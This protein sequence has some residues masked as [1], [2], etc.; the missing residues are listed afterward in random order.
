MAIAT[1]L[2]THAGLH[3]QTLP[4]PPASPAPQVSF[5]YDAE[6]NLRGTLQQ[7]PGAN[8]VTRHEHD[9]L[10]RR[11]RTIDAR[12]NSVWQV[13]NGRDDLTGV[14]DP[15]L[16]FTQY[17]RDGLGNMLSLSSPDT[18]TARI[19]FDAAGNLRTRVDSR[20]VLAS[21]S[22]DALNRLTGLDF[23]AG[24]GSQTFAWTYDQ[25][26]NDHAH[27]VGRLTT[28]QFPGGFTRYAY[29]AQGRLSQSV[30]TVNTSAGAVTTG[31][32]YGRDAAGRVNRVT[33]PSGR[34]LHI[35][36][37]GGVPSALSLAPF[38]GGMALPLL[39]SLQFEPG[40][41]GAG[42]LRSWV[43]QLSAGTLA[44]ERVFD[45]H[46]RMVRHPLGGAVRDIVYDAADRIA[47][48]SHLDA[49][50]GQASAA[51][52]ALNQ[53]FGYDELGRLTT[54]GTPGGQWG[55][56]YDDNGNRT[57]LSYTSGVVSLN[58]SHSV[59]PASNRV[60]GVASP[61][62]SFT[63][64]ATGHMTGTAEAGHGWTATVDPGGRIQ[65]IQSVAPMGGVSA[66][67]QYLHNAA[68]LRVAK[69]VL[70]GGTV[71][72]NPEPIDPVICP[73]SASQATPCP[74]QPT[75]PAVALGRGGGS[76]ATASSAGLNAEVQG[77]AT[78]TVYVH[79]PEG[80]LLGEYDG[81]TGAVLRE[82]VWLQGLPLVVV[83]GSAANPI[84]YYVQTD[85]IDTPRVLLDRAGRQR[86]SW[87]AEPF[88]NSAPVE[89]PVGFGPVKFN[90]RMPGQ[91]F[92][93]E[94]G[95][96]DNW[97]RSYD[98]G[99]G[100]YTQSDPIG[101]AGG[102]NTYS[103]AL[104]QP[105]MYSDPTGLFTSSTHNEIT[106]AAIAIAGSPCPSLPGGVANADWFPGSQAPRNA[107]WHAMRDGTNPDATVTSASRDYGE[108][109]GGQLKSCTC[110]GLARAMHAVQDSY[111]RGHAGFQ[112][113]SGGMPSASHV[114]A[115][116]YPS[117][118]EREG[119]IKASVDLI[120]RFGKDCKDQC[121]R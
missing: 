66:S 11:V 61:T 65:A 47:G 17:G 20:G 28:A 5:E 10:Q 12:G 24:F 87:V 73:G 16:L 14:T 27:G 121:P 88:G 98:A 72:A 33:Y 82:Y 50:T 40:P 118:G 89:D 75:P 31:V 51:T 110:E 36:H 8:L 107:H 35:V 115:D 48:F 91:Y 113:W 21:Y 3:A 38:A 30:Q 43:W 95:L 7:V 117:K 9:R 76:R 92:D 56:A 1:L 54:V 67:A 55:Y 96:S 4:A 60:L 32:G 34:V 2:L 42:A 26:G 109:V 119:A 97:H 106:A 25:T 94:S 114:R 59:D 100:R 45:L 86:W 70:A 46:G 18:G 13:Y 84:I 44:H 85:H 105:T 19:T 41:G 104:N 83:D 53:A 37:A 29:D 71:I 62:R 68:G 112:P 81:A 69:L 111:A 93:E 22:Y 79:G 6:G 101:L 23:S 99:L 39:S 52:Q 103:Y 15:R 57:L 77:G 80:E 102:I 78:A 64:D 74:G 49:I 90:L 108:F 58:R 63:Y 116:S 120:R